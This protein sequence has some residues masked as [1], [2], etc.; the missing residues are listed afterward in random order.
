M[1]EE[2]FKEQCSFSFLW[3]TKRLQ[4]QTKAGREH[5]S[6]TEDIETFTLKGLKDLAS[7][8]GAAQYGNRPRFAACGKSRAW[9]RPCCCKRCLTSA[10]TRRMQRLHAT[11][12]MTVEAKLPE[13]FVAQYGMEFV[14]ENEPEGAV[15]FRD[16]EERRKEGIPAEE[17]IK[18]FATP[19]S[20]TPTKSS[21][22]KS[23]RRRRVMAVVDDSDDEESEESENDEEM[24][25]FDAFAERLEQKIGDDRDS[26]LR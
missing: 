24:I 7:R 14:S 18:K 21:P 10:K 5:M 3:K 12:Y 25:P 11:D 23:L 8:L 26:S 4:T 13:E 2:E 9:V 19:K 6:Y 16:H 17:V 1:G 22:V 15:T 20:A